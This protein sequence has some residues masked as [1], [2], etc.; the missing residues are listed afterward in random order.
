MQIKHYALL[1]ITALSLA[2]AGCG[3]KNGA[4]SK[5][6]KDGQTAS[7]ER[8]FDE[9][10]GKVEMK[11]SM[12]GMTPTMTLYFDDYGKKTATIVQMDMMGKQMTQH[13]ISI[14]D[15]TIQWN[16]ETM[17]G[18]RTSKAQGADQ[19]MSLTA[20]M[21]MDDARKKSLNYKEIGEKEVLG[22]KATGF[23]VDTAGVTMKIWH[24][25]NIPVYME[26]NAQGMTVTF[27][28]TKIDVPSDVPASTF[29]VPAAVK[30]TGATAPMDTS[31]AAPATPSEPDTS[32]KK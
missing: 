7:G 18:T 4:D 8:I 5:D 16:D 31:S 11:M 27:E 3:D 24:W 20:Y 21:N 23:S 9:K 30:F 17:E 10:S 2:I 22:K 15:T 6:S 29:E 19:K 32:T 14:G 1:T 12:M 28:A 13:A 26:A 25:H